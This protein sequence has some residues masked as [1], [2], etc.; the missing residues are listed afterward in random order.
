MNPSRRK[1]LQCFGS[2]GLGLLAAGAPFRQIHDKEVS[3]M[4]QAPR[5]ITLFLCGDV[6]TG[7]GIDQ[8]LPKPSAPHLYE[9]YVRNAKIYIKLAERLNGPIAQPADFSYIWGEA[10]AELDRTG[11]DVRIVNLETAI[12]TSDDYWPD[13][14]INYRMHPANSPCLTAARIDC[15][16][17]ANNHVIDW[18]YKGLAETLEVLQQASLKTAGAGRNSREAEAPAVMNLAGKGRVLVFGFGCDSSGIPTEWAAADDKPGVNRLPDL[19]SETC[20]RLRNR[21]RR[22]K[23]A[24][25][26][27]VA[28]IHWGGNW[29]YAIPDQ[30][31]RFAHALIDEAGVDI[32]HGHSSHHPKAAEVYRGKLIL[33]GCGDFIND[34]EGIEGYESYRGDL[35]LMYFATMNPADGTLSGLEM[36]PLH[37]RRF[38]LDRP[39]EKDFRWMRERLERES[40]KFGGA[41]EA[42]DDRRLVLRWR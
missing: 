28:S 34:Y 41:V 39:S 27:V 36:I 12:T 37:M 14:G 10:L 22:I 6:M 2:A 30:Q 11:P 19:S 9:P 31:R 18:G 13:K 16:V 4:E 8:I 35:V 17:L 42:L 25:D 3:P 5:R 38:R 40:G 32:V 20:H 33:Y 15:C 21:L 23:Q 29:G 24:R 26:I 7:R 1:L